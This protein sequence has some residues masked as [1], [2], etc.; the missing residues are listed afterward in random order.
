[1]KFCLRQGWRSVRMRQRVA[2][3]SPRIA[4]DQCGWERIIRKGWGRQRNHYLMRRA[5]RVVFA[6]HPSI[7]ANAVG[8]TQAGSRDWP[9]LQFDEATESCWRIPISA[10][11]VSLSVV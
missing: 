8:A 5:L 1:M 6:Q 2:T 10:D 4:I 11:G 9:G 7:F 3:L